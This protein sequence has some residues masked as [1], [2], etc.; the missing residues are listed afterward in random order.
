MSYT[1][2][3]L[4]LSI[5]LPT[6]GALFLAFRFGGLTLDKLRPWGALLA[7]GSLGAWIVLVALDSPYAHA[8]MSFLL[9]FV[10]GV[11]WIAWF[12]RRSK[13]QS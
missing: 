3:V 9:S 10:V 6:W 13:R 2:K 8:A 12:E 11:E 1:A 4:I 5:P 7:F